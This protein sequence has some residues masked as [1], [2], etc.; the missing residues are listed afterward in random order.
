[1]AGGLLSQ[2]LTEI[3]PDSEALRV[4]A[5]DPAAP[6][7]VGTG[8]LHWQLP[9]PHVPASSSEELLTQAREPA[10]ST[11]IAVPWVRVKSLASVPA[12]DRLPRRAELH[13]VVTAL[14]VKHAPEGTVVTVLA[15]GRFVSEA[16]R[17]AL[18]EIR[19]RAAP[20]LVVDG[21]SRL[22][23]DIGIQAAVRIVLVQFRV[24]EVDR[25]L[26]RFV[27]L[28]RLSNEDDAVVVDELRKLLRSQ[29]GAGRIGWVLREEIG[30]QVPLRPA[31]HAPERRERHS[32]LRKV[33]D[34][35]PLERL[36]D[37]VRPVRRDLPGEGPTRQVRLL[38]DRA[39]TRDG[40]IDL[41]QCRAAT[42]AAPDESALRPGDVCF[43]TISSAGDR[44]RV[45]CATFPGGVATDVFP[46]QSVAVLRFRDG[47]DPTTEEFVRA[48]LQS[49]HA[50]MML[51][52]V[53]DGTHLSERQL[54]K[55]EVPLPDETLRRTLEA[56]RADERQLGIWT[57]ELQEARRY[58]L[59]DEDV[60]RS[61][62]DVQNIGRLARQRVAAADRMGK[63]DGRIQAFMPYPLALMWRGVAT[64][65]PD[66]AGYLLALQCAEAVSCYLACIAVLFRR[67]AGTEEVGPVKSLRDSLKR[68]GHGVSMGDWTAIAA[69]AATEDAAD[70]RTPFVE[71]RE[72]VD[73]G[74]EVLDALSALTQRRND[75]AHG[76]GP[77]GRSV[78]AEAFDDAVA[79]LARVYR[80]I[81][82]LMRYPLRLVEVTVWD[83]LRRSCA[84]YYRELVGDHHLVSLR[85]E[86][87]PS[88][89]YDAGRLYCVDQFG[90]LHL[91]DPMLTLRVCDQCHLPSV[92]A[93]N[94]WDR[95]TDVTTLR[96]LD[97]N[98]VVGDAEVSERLRRFGFLPPPA[99]TRS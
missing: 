89:E 43:R 52:G 38:E 86:T 5:L 1:M 62:L 29:G 16:T 93:L 71:I 80:G 84:L 66:D 7:L 87:R 40:R 41:E 60:H 61:V 12:F 68:G 31:F 78:V 2:V 24:G 4:L 20:Q 54:L 22:A 56:L 73:R 51:G 67:A 19:N 8:A 9:W 96:A 13:E 81:E 83:S 58:L 90:D 50:E 76:R 79:D 77:R 63:L 95:K 21:G 17:T 39:I 48:Y 65:R 46:T 88:P 85:D 27:E 92:F 70:E 32:E 44:Q 72:T 97:H 91:I 37:R 53:I 11:V 6:D 28:D 23:T 18:H 55:L 33:G 42:G 75:H 10:A 30:S 69:S 3:V 36:A 59:R 49:P 25:P 26:T 99:A 14:V 34:P 74:S 45:V 64:S 35:V 15:P 98:H 47:I 57:A 82:W 94:T